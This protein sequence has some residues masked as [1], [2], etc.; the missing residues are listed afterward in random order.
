MTSRNSTE[1]DFKL[2]KLNLFKYDIS[3][4]IP[5]CWK[6]ENNNSTPIPRCRD[7]L[8]TNRTLSYPSYLDFISNLFENNIPIGHYSFYLLRM[9]PRTCANPLGFQQDYIKLP[10]VKMDTISYSANWF[11]YP[12]NLSSVRNSLE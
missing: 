1:Q 12:K 2:I 6:A 3:Y 7:D 8:G 10:E 11:H 4:L 5:F 9:F